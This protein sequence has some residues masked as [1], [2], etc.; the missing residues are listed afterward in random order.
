VT[1]KG[2]FNGNSGINFDK[3]DDIPVE[4]TG[5]NVPK[6]VGSVSLTARQFKTANRPLSVTKFTNHFKRNVS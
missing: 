5:E 6:S 1:L 2:L 4:A 3:Y